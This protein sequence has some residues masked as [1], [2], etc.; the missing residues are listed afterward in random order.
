MNNAR[1]AN[2]VLN[3]FG[4]FIEEHKKHKISQMKSEFL[5][6]CNERKIIL[7]FSGYCA[8]DELEAALVRKITKGKNVEKEHVDVFRS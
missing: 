6:E 2:V 1:R 3:E 5:G 8:L 7:M 4:S